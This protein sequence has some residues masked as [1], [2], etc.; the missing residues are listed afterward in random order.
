MEP[1]SALED[2]ALEP[3]PGGGRH[4]DR[5]GPP[6]CTCARRRARRG[7]APRGLAP[8]WRSTT[9]WRGA[10][11]TPA[12]YP[13]RAPARGQARERQRHRARPSACADT[14]PA[15]PR[16]RCWPCATHGIVD[17][18]LVVDAG[19]RRRHRRG[20][21]RSS[22][23]TSPRRTTLLPQFGPAQGK[24]DAMW[25]GLSA[26]GGDIVAF[27]DADSDRHPA[28]L[29]ARPARPAAVPR[30]AGA[31]QGR[32]RAPVPA[33]RARA[34]IPHGGGRVTE[35]MARP[36]IN[37]H[38]PQLAGFSQP[39]AGEVAA[40][41]DAARAA[42]VPGRLRRRDRHAHRR[43]ARGRPR[44]SRPGATSACARTATSRCA[45]SA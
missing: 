18:L 40:R 5:R 1:L 28:R 23:S 9:G 17:E 8:T 24:G 32:L 7:R 3:P 29:R 19:S 4:P 20:V 11:T 6:P 35:L 25:R 43:A 22:A 36:L 27:L 34:P 26:T 44:P 21:R 45:T 14:L 16:R 13:A 38:V 30:R 41:R 37:L 2:E 33:R 15:R 39:L 42:V 12:D 31:G 10:P